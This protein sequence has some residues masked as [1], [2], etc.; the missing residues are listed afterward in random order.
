MESLRKR[1]TADLVLHRFAPDTM[2]HYL[3]CVE[4]LARHFARSPAAL[5][6]D[7]VRSFLVYLAREKRVHPTTQRMYVAAFRFLYIVT[8]RRPEVVSDVPWPRVPKPLPDI[9][10]GEEVEQIVAAVGSLQHQTLLL[11]AYAGGLRVSEAC[12]L[13]VGDIDSKRGVIHVRCGKRGKDRYVMLSQRLLVLLR[14]YW[15]RSRPPGPYLFPGRKPERP[16]TVHAVQ[17]ALKMA[18]IH[19]GLRKRVTPHSLR[20]AF[21]THLLENGTDVRV[22]QRLLGHASIRST[23]RYAH[24][25]LRHI[26]RTPSP[27]DTLGQR[28]GK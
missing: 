10:S 27:L 7:E 25:S 3:G 28:D 16:I 18:V 13:Q 15:R 12:K 5:G 20:H 26:A 4:V 14:E 9:L 6:A 23:E 2:A 17:L 22:I 1:M 8:L 11:T 24:V 21:A 19:L